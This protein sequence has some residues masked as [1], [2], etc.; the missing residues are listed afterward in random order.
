MTASLPRGGPARAGPGMASKLHRP[1]RR[2]QPRSR[3]GWLAAGG[4]IANLLVAVLAWVALRTLP[5]DRGPTRDFVWLLLA[6]NVL[7]P[8]GYLLFSGVGGIG[9]W[10]VVVEGLHP[11][12]AWRLGLAVV[13]AVLYLVV[14]PP[15][16][17]AELEPFL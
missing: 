5:G 16:L 11:A 3:Q 17:M 7:T 8:F 15:L 1:R 2:A 9:D 14:T 12:L 10:A 4:S 6:V 13:G